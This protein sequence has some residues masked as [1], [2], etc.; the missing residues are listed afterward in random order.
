MSDDL[1][2]GGPSTTSVFTTELEEESTRLT[3][4]GWDLD[5]CHRELLSLDRVIGT[6][7][8]SAADAPRSA[9]LAESAIDEAELALR[10]ALGNCDQLVR[11]L[12]NAI[13]GYE[14]TD[15]F[16]GRLEQQ[17]AADV[18]YFLGVV[19]PILAAV[20]LPFAAIAGAGVAAFLSTLPEQSRAAVFSSTGSWLRARCSGLTDPNFVTAVRYSVMSADDVAWGAVRLPPELASIFGDEGLGI[21][22]VDTS[23][24][25]VAAAASGL[26]LLRETPVRVTAG[27]T[28]Y[29][30][31]DADRIQDKVERIPDEPEQIRI[32]RYSTPGEPDR[33]EVYIAGTA[34][35]D[36][37]G[38]IEAWDMTSN[39][40]AMGGGS[41]GSGAASY[42]A[43]VEAMS[44]AG[45]GIESPVTFAGYSQGGII[46]AQLAAS[47]YYTVDGLITVGAPAGQ[48]AVPHEIPYLA[49]EHTDDLVP[50]LGGTFAA[51]DPTLVRRQV[52][53]TPPPVG[54]FVLP[55][56]QLSNYLETARLIDDSSNLRL[57]ALL[58]QLSHPHAHEVSSTLFRADRIP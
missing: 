51:S 22:G 13:R 50:A 47:G 31:S 19:A 37:D 54:E 8:L 27:T 16:I 41:D 42:R 52:F 5:A 23:A 36:I 1:A 2:I 53:D 56:H 33:F 38:G 45:I 18:G 21:L 4:L 7:L 10:A 11:G 44:L 34:D 12:T 55:A 48:V 26:G 39:L 49:I 40:A 28:F 6:G 24:A 57:T 3:H 46:A 29:G 14:L 15:Q 25:T 17:L 30:L 32:D 43:V 35:L 58:Q 20:F 9:L